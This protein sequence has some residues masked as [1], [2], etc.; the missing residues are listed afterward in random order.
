MSKKKKSSEASRIKEPKLTD[1]EIEARTKA[2]WTSERMNQ[3]K[4]I[5]LE[6]G[7]AKNKDIKTETTTEKGE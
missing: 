7:D 6:I 5:G 2:H 4:P 1:K 3:A